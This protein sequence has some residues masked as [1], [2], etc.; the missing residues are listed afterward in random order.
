MTEDDNEVFER[1]FKRERDAGLG[2]TDEFEVGVVRAV[3]RLAFAAGMRHRAV[4]RNA[5]IKR[6]SALTADK[7]A[8]NVG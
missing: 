2:V 8:R 7:G 5:A 3:A 4:K 1:W 6:K